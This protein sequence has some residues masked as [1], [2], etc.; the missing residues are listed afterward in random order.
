VNSVFGAKRPVSRRRVISILAAAGAG[1]AI[2]GSRASGSAAYQWKGIALGA[3]AD[4]T[5]YATD[6]ARAEGII[7]ACL[8]EVARLEAMFSLH[9]PDSTLS[10]L[11]R[12]GRVAD[13]PFEFIELLSQ[14]LML[15]ELSGGRFDP[16]VQP[17]WRVYSEHF[18][19]PK[20][21]PAGPPVAQ[22]A[23]ARA[24]VDWR[25]VHLSPREVTFDLPGMQVTL[26]GIAQGYVS[27]R[28]G[29]LLNAEGYTHALVNLGETLAID[30]DPGDDAWW[31]GIPSPI[32]RTRLLDRV[33]IRDGA[34]AT[35]AGYGMRFDAS[36]RFNHIVDP[37]CF[38][39]ADPD[40]SVTVLARSAAIAD[41][42]STLGALSLD[43]VRD[44]NPVLRRFAA[45][46]IVASGASG[47]TFQL[48]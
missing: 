13:P 35:S 6:R 20:A 36:G 45:R 5:L 33:A 21:D 32:D 25:R 16:T 48:G 38:S 19:A 11:N 47:T 4:L 31:V 3:R 30:R 7:A 27:D 37:T 1:A 10:R 29:N 39:C 2:L 34:I 15:G 8:S 18:A 22:L 40:R 12:D 43:L 42:L 46:A 41:G 44:F 26:N 23:S 14:A 17:L 24:L 28:I 9:Q